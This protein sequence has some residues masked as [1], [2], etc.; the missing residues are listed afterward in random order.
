MVRNGTQ[1]FE[2]RSGLACASNVWLPDHPLL[3]VTALSLMGVEEAT[4][5]EI[6]QQIR[7]GA[8]EKRA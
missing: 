7:K 2:L 4:L 5:K 3:G 1:R 6:V 8:E